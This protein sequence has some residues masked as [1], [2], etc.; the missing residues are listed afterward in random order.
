MGEVIELAPHR[1][2]RTAAV[3]NQPGEPGDTV[4]IAVEPVERLA[5][6]QAALEC[7]SLGLSFGMSWLLTRCPGPDGAAAIAAAL[8]AVDVRLEALQRTRRQAEQILR[9]IES[10]DVAACQAL[11]DQLRAEQSDTAET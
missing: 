2:A 1:A 5:V 9:L 4:V 3:S 10:G 11:R 8:A 7:A 6:A